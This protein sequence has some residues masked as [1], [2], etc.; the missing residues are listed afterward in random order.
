MDIR[1]ITLTL[2]ITLICLSSTGQSPVKF[3][4]DAAMGHI[5]FL[6]SEQL[7]GRKSGTA[8][9]FLAADYIRGE[10]M[11]AGAM[12]FANGGFQEFEIITGISTGNANNLQIDSRT[13]VLGE[14]YTPLPFSKNGFLTAP[15]LFVGYG[16]DISNDSLSWNDY[17]GVDMSGKW[18]LILRGEPKSAEGKALL[19][20]NFDERFKVMIAQ[21]HGAAGVIFVTG[22][23][24]DSDDNLLK[25]SYDRSPSTS[26]I[27]V[28]QVK[29]NVIDPLVATI[30]KTLEMIEKEIAE[31]RASP[32]IEIPATI[33]AN[34]DLVKNQAMAYNVVAMIEGVDPLLK[35]QFVVIGAHYDHLGLGGF[36][37]G[38]RVPDTV[39][40]HYGADDNAS[41]VAATIE[42]AK[43][44]AQPEN[45]PA[46]SLV[47]IAFDAE[48]MGLIGSRY[49]ADNPPI[50]LTKVTAMIN[51]DMIGRL[52][53]SN[54]ISVGG[55]GTSLETTQILDRFAEKYPLKLA[56]STEG[57]G[58]SDHA[59]FYGKNIPVFFIS[60]GAHAD[61][62][63]PRDN[64]EGI[65][66][67]GIVMVLDFS[68]GLVAELAN[69]AEMLTFQEAGPSSRGDHRYNFKVTLGIMPDMTSS[70]N[71]G[72]KVEA[73]RPGAPAA[74]GGML[75][76]DVI[77]AIDGNPVGNI[78]D[79]MGRLKNLEAGQV[80]TVDVQREGKQEVLIIQL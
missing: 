60:T 56:Y 53:E 58:P 77:T 6:A 67:E 8:G 64:P 33:S 66:A 47:F 68:A 10:F 27:P 18:A 71:D 80:I 2:I 25:L 63:T 20:G 32:A 13:F 55:T 22:A 50:D 40:V 38:S 30:G 74:S 62:H 59:A 75:K 42:I 51:F 23:Q 14:D 29:R 43:Y 48:E 65:N 45:K 26:G 46:R 1:K 41:G 12:P 79:Y 57:F 76:G 9:A 52:K 24:L 16:L 37:S 21:D 3:T 72:L 11:A 73:V 5:Q 34:V 44:F 49:F 61:Y 28:L 70:G 15:A 78:Y 31:N 19:S 69:R 35:D 4:P 7:Q 36:G 17:D 39:A 54:T